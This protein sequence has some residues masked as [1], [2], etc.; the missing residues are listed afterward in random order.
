MRL[1]NYGSIF[2]DLVFKA[3]R[4]ATGVIWR[5]MIDGGGEVMNLTDVDWGALFASNSLFH[6]DSD[7][8]LQAIEQRERM[9]D[10]EELSWFLEVI[11]ERLQVYRD[12][13]PHRKFEQE[14]ALAFGHQTDLLRDRVE[15][16]KQHPMQC[17]FNMYLEIKYEVRTL[18]K[19]V[20]S[21]LSGSDWQAPA[22]EVAPYKT[23]VPAEAG[24]T[25]EEQGTYMRTYGSEYVKTY[26]EKM[27][28][29]FY[30]MSAEAR[31]KCIRYLTSS[32]MN[33]LELALVAYK[34]HT[35]EQLPCYVQ[36]GFYCEGN[37][38]A[39]ALLDHSQEKSVE[40]IYE[41]V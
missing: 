13:F 19:Q 11:H 22:I 30:P 18:H 24:Y 27:L 6:W 1:N 8:V 3:S 40:E 25:Q 15:M 37:D 28:N 2:D 33:A 35:A 4:L 12:E 41:A 17:N 26:E 29:A 16:Y 39:S 7:S 23:V 36:T 20:G 34:K 38:L 9:E 21:V 14:L 32:G 31:K 5:E 10:L